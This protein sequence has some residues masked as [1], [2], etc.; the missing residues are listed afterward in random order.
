MTL[1]LIYAKQ[2]VDV[3]IHMIISLNIHELLQFTINK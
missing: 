2:N 3:L 1:F